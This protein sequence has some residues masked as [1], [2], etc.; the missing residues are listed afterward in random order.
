MV[1]SLVVLRNNLVFMMLAF[2]LGNNIH[3]I[4]RDTSEH[5]GNANQCLARGE[6]SSNELT[7]D[8]LEYGALD[9]VSSDH[10]FKSEGEGNL[11]KLG[12]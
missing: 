7:E 12:C 10:K 8:R 1:T 3:V 4:L 5:V 2:F 6:L 9:H 11:T